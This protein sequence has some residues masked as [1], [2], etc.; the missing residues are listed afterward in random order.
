MIREKIDLLNP[1]HFTQFLYSFL[2]TRFLSMK[3]IYTEHSRWQLEMLP[4]HFKLLNVIMLI[5]SEGIVAISEQIR[6]Y[7]ETMIG[8]R[9][10]KVHL[11]KNGIDIQLFE[12]AKRSDLRRELNIG[13]RAKIIGMVANIRS[14][15][16]H[17]LLISAFS[18]IAREVDDAFLVMVGLDFMNGAV[19]L[20]ANETG[21]RDRI[22]FLGERD[23]VPELLKTFD[24]FCLPS[25][26]EGMPLTL[27]E[28]M[29]AGVPVI[30]SDV[31]GINEVIEH[32]VNGLLFR[33]NDERDLA[34]RVIQLLNNEEM[35][36][37][38]SRTAKSH[39]RQNYSLDNSINEY[40]RL[41]QM[42]CHQS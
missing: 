31:L 36:S 35:R 15:K 32:N 38:F 19:Q 10:N 20:Y 33:G 17:K 27:L 26:H 9:R 28:A 3:V 42:Q 2:A 13:E 25:I 18:T 29:A 14:E 23:D 39:A 7:Y 24:L 40:D 37:R 16:N 12:N 22:F 11:I 8:V 4:F 30:G 34:E 41:F 5:N 21:L 6:N 1:H